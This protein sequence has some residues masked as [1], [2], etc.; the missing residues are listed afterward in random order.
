[1]KVIID[2][3][4]GINTPGKRSP[5][6]PDGSQLFEYEFNRSIAAMVLHELEHLGIPYLQLVPEI[7]DISLRERCNRANI[8]YENHPDSFLVSIH[9]NAGG[10]TGWEVFTYTGQSES[11]IIA[12][13]FAEMAKLHFPNFRMRFDCSDGDPDKESQFYILKHT[14]CPAILTE[15]FFMDTPKDLDFICS[16]S[17]RKR[18]ATMHVEA[19]KVYLKSKGQL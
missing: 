17:G 1:M 13:V 15:N 12:N 2:N 4:H 7:E 9:A 16:Y 8:F 6:R 3:G 11:D 14:K 18:I 5:I 10:G 19:I